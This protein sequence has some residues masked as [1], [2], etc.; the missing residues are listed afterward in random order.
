MLA[1]LAALVSLHP[2]SAG[3]GYLDAVRGA[4]AIVGASSTADRRAAAAADQMMRE[5]TG[6]SQPEILRSLESNPPDLA[7]AG[8]RLRALRTALEAGPSP[9]NP[10]AARDSLARVLADPRYAGLS[11]GPSLGEIILRFLAPVLDP[12]MR[13]LARTLSGH[14]GQIA[15]TVLAAGVVLLVTVVLWLVLRGVRGRRR[16]A[17]EAAGGAAGMSQRARRDRFLEADRL[18]GG[19]D[20]EAALRALA[21]GVA[22]T[23]SG[24]GAWEASPLTVREIF[25][26]APEAASLRPLLVAFEAAVYGHRP[27]SRELYERA[28][29]AA[30]PYR[31]RDMAA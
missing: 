28:A 20:Y 23:I 6:T 17:G 15:R 24:E 30:A 18:A 3:I 5:G 12:I 14:G 31:P 21:G 22:T 10:G 29:T 13:W 1:L 8:T 4:E 16:G 19:G 11:G 26:N 9:S 7:S 2:A 25:R 27:V